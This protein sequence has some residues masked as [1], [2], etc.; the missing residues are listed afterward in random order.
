MATPCRFISAALKLG[1]Y[2]LCASSQEEKEKDLNIF[3]LE[4]TMGVGELLVRGIT[5]DKIYQGSRLL[6]FSMFQKLGQV[7][8]WCLTRR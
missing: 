4:M 1:L 6:G 8:S 5:P 3:E 7:F 2:H